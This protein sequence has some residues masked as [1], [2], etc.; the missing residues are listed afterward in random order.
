M[1][2]SA[3]NAHSALRPWWAIARA[4]AYPETNPGRVCSARCAPCACAR[5]LPRVNHLDILNGLP[6]LCYVSKRLGEEFLK[7]LA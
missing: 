5:C 2:T 4:D 3:S 7:P 1:Q 6:V